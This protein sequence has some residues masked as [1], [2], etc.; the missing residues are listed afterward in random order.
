[1]RLLVLLPLLLSATAA[2]S[3][4]KPKANCVEI[5]AQEFLTNVTND[6]SIKIIDVRMKAEF[7]TGYIEKAV[8]IPISKKL[9]RKVKP[10][11]KTATYYLYCAGGTRSCRAAAQYT[12]AGFQHVYSLKGGING[13]KRE[14]LA[15]V[16]SRK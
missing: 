4:E 12:A 2:F 1:M 3:Q 13:W 11:D 8:N 14:G 16:G 5:T 9:P 7:K 10:F 6:S 15:V